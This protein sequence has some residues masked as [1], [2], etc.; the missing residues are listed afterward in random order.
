MSRRP[1]GFCE[2][3][4]EGRRRDAI[5]CSR[6]CK[7]LS[8]SGGGRKLDTTR[9]CEICGVS[10]T[11][12]KI[13]ALACSV[14]CNNARLMARRKAEKW[15]GV[16]PDRPCLHCGRPLSGKRPQAAYCDRTCKA[17]GSS[18]RREADGRGR[19]KSTGRRAKVKI[20]PV[21]PREVR[22]M[23]HRQRGRCFYCDVVLSP[24]YHLDHV[25]PLSRGGLHSIGNL[26]IAC[27]SCNCSKRNKFIV[28]WRRKTS[29]RQRG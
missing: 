6:R 5:Y 16:D 21:P 24:K 26:V 18:Q 14:E 7:A 3:S 9:T 28:E 12:R 29:E 13:T 15:Q 11:G 19:L 2:G 23:F 1:C 4:M 25:V 27:I 22:G 10:L 20:A 17:A 8:H